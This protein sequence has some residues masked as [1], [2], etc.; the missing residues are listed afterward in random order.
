MASISACLLGSAQ[1]E[2]RKTLDEILDNKYSVVYMTPEYCC[3]DFGLG[4]IYNLLHLRKIG[5]IKL[6]LIFTDFLKRMDNT[7]SLILIAIDEAH[8]VSTWG[9]DFRFSYRNLG[10][11]RK[12]LSHIPILAVTA[13]ATPRVRNDITKSL[14]LR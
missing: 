14:M 6:L 9:H 13:T 3:G 12:V 8:C 2:K 1:K 11:I 7:L 5:I 4:N 10:T